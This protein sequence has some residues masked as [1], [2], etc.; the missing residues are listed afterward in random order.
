MKV[1]E[2]EKG[3]QKSSF[4]FR[5]YKKK[6]AENESSEE[7]TFLYVHQE[8][9]QKGLLT[10]YGNTITLM[11]AT[12]KTTKYS[13]PLFF[14][15]VKTNV[16]YTVVTEFVLQSENTNHI[17]E[18]LSIIKSWTPSWDPKYFITDYSDAE[19]SAVSMLF[20]QTQF[21]LCDF[22]REQAWERWVKNRKHGLSEIQATTLLDLLRD[23][24]NAPVNSTVQNEPSD[25]LFKKALKCITSSDIWNNNKEVQQWLSPM[26]LSCPKLWAR[27]YRDQAYHAAVNTTNGVESQNKL[28]KYSYLPR[29]KNI[30]ISRL[31]TVLYKDFNPEIHHKYLF[32]NYKSSSF[33]RTYNDFVPSY[34][35]GRPRQVILHCL[36]RKSSSRKYDES[37]ITTQDT[38]SG[39]FIIKGSSSKLHRVNFG[40]TTGE[41]SCT[42][43]DWIEWRI[44]C[45]H[46]F[47]VFRFFEKWRWDSLPEQYKC[48][49]HISSSVG[50]TK[51]NTP[52]CTHTD[53]VKED[54]PYMNQTELPTKK[55]SLFNC[56]LH[57]CSYVCIMH[58]FLFLKAFNNCLPANSASGDPSNLEGIRVPFM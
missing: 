52:S 38:I 58:F 36:E 44:P 33:Y 46:F 20:P 39:V 8:E 22:H 47:A 56:N 3:N 6:A 15:C 29:R 13:I 48:Q 24:A 17:F 21:Y 26:W 42:C 57:V 49:P 30:T 32:L 34:L 9:W 2:W 28:L 14:L 50:E 5:P 23:C 7:Q 53:T 11:D 25:Y 19:M 18:A 40:T 1:E 45:K 55:V 54:V 12:Y 4:Y 10:T 43:H 35:H 37:D 27:S 51:N 31:A 16:N 41:L